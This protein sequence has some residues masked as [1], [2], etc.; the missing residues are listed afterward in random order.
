MHHS[1]F[2]CACFEFEL[3]SLSTKRTPRGTLRT[4]S[5]E[6]HIAKATVKNLWTWKLEVVTKAI[7]PSLTPKCDFGFINDYFDIN[8]DLRL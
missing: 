4:I 5:K 8:I 2:L 3:Q 1:L 6:T 7:I